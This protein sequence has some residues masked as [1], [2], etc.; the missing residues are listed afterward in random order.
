MKPRGRSMRLWHPNKKPVFSMGNEPSAPLPAAGLLTFCRTHAKERDGDKRCQKFGGR[1]GKPDT[2]HPPDFW[3]N[4]E[5]QKEQGKR[6]QESDRARN[7]P[8]SIGHHADRREDIDPGEEETESI[9]PHAGYGEGEYGAFRVGK[10]GNSQWREEI[11]QRVDDGRRDGKEPVS[12]A[13]QDAA[14]SFPVIPAGIAEGRRYPHGETKINADKQKLQIHDDGDSRNAVF[15]CKSEGGTVEYD[16]RNSNG[17]LVHKFGCAVY[18]AAC[19]LPP[20]QAVQCEGE[21]LPL[22]EKVIEPH[23]KGQEQ[24]EHCSKRRPQDSH[25]ETA[26]KNIVQNDIQDASG[27]RCG[28]AVCRRAVDPDEIGK[29]F[30]PD[31]D[32]GSEEPPERIYS[33]AIHGQGG[34][35]EQMQDTGQMQKNDEGK[36]AAQQ[37]GCGNADRE[38]TV[39]RIFSV[40]PDMQCGNGA[41]AG[42]EDQG[43]AGQ[44]ID[45][46]VND[47][48]GS[49]SIRTHICRDKDTVDDGVDGIEQGSQISGNDTAQQLSESNFFF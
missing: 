41:A 9:D 7:M 6:A 10:T 21:E 1:R 45:N 48:D 40:S 3:K 13:L 24:A 26:D 11:C 18:H 12:I 37:N 27:E 2:R 47:V 34:G 25:P 19:R 4:S 49:Q 23:T 15:S 33:A 14:D 16:G 29:Q 31:D 32:G 28:E 36:Q 22:F 35:A 42:C 39:R 38:R 17:Q 46:G 5:K 8:F 20:G 44:H 30:F 43:D